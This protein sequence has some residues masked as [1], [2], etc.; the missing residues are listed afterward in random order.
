MAAYVQDVVTFNTNAGNKQATITPAANALLVVF[1][2]NTGIT[3]TPGMTDDQ[4]GTYDLIRAG[5]RNASA[6]GEWCFI[7]TA[8]C[9]PVAHVVTMATSGSDT[10]GGLDVIE[11]S[12][13]Q[14]VG[15]LAVR[16]STVHN[17]MTAGAVPDAVFSAACLT[18]NMVLACLASQ[19]N[20]NT[21]TN[22]SGYTQRQNVG[23]NVPA[24]GL[25]THTRD[26]GET[27]TTITWG[28]TETNNSGSIAVELNIDGMTRNLPTFEPVPFIPKGR[29]F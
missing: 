23:Y 19:D 29:S 17:N 3:T 18:Q 4:G 20:V 7:R 10:G 24:A 16:Q 22:P 15:A 26:S 12:G 14:R 11:V 5:L 27:T 28:G 25:G 1:C 21:A 2:A 8:L 6:S 9:K 13:M